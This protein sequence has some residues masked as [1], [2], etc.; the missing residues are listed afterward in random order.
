MGKLGRTK[1]E[2]R[3]E[4]TQEYWGHT[5]WANSE[6]KVYASTTEPAATVS[7]KVK[8]GYPLPKPGPGCGVRAVGVET[9]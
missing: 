8:S 6:D 3:A 9:T 4:D 2:T 7:P 1:P 5:K